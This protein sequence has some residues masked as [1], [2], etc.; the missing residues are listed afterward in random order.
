[1]MGQ[2]CPIIAATYG[3]FK[4]NLFDEFERLEGEAGLE[5]STCE[6][7]PF[8]KRSRAVGVIENVS[9]SFTAFRM[10]ATA[11]VRTQPHTVRD[12]SYPTLRLLSDF[13]VF[14]DLV[15]HVGEG[16]GAAAGGVLRVLDA[17]GE[18]VVTLAGG[19]ELVGDVEGGEDGYAEAVDGVAVGGDGAHLGVYDGGEALDVGGVGAAE[20]VDLVVDID[21]D[22]LGDGLVFGGLGR[23]LGGFESLVHWVSFV[24]V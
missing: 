9:G 20:I 6:G 13:A 22:G 19:A 15:E 21:R 17:A 5:Q 8:D 4:L 14:E 24:L 16:G 18:R 3:K 11:N 7:L 12:G 10:T 2:A 23:G 1:M